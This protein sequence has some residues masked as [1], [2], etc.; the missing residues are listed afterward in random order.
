[1]FQN[2]D[3]ALNYNTNTQVMVLK[4]RT[5]YSALSHQLVVVMVVQQITLVVMVVLVAEQQLVSVITPKV[6][7][8]QLQVKVTMVE[9]VLLKI[10]ETVET[11][12][13]VAVELVK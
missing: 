10:M 9:A 4:V 6:E 3:P 11:L 5:L 7:E 12:L 1:M 8:V 2:G 13:V